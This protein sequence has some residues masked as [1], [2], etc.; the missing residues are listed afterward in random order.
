MKRVKLI[1]VDMDGTL[2][3]SDH[4]T[5][6]EENIRAI[7]RANDLG[8]RVAIST[9]RMLEDASDFIHRHGLPCMII[10]GNG[11]RA[12]DGPLPEGHIFWRKNL[13]P[14]DAHRAVDVMLA[15]GLLINGFEDGRV[16]TVDYG[17]NWTYHGV[18][19]G[20]MTAEY[21]ESALRAAADRGILKL[22]CVSLDAS[23][24]RDERVS[25][26]LAAAREALPNLSVTSSGRDN[27]EIIPKDAGKGAA[28]EAMAKR[29]KLTC[30]QVMA[31]GDAPNDMSMLEYAFHSVAMGNAMPEVKAVCRYETVT[32]DECGVARIIERVLAAKE[33]TAWR[34]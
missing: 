9:G 11:A 20:L 1:A 27:V 4:R 22:F 5:V 31:V 6:P 14:D 26:A 25:K 29:L 17:M 23:G 12:S 30:E 18:R 13:P 16:T 3:A 32:N 24:E 2:L 15:S 21:G 10:A 33:E 28:L 8:V 34:V 19:R 7:R